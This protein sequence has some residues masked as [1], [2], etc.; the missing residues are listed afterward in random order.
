MPGLGQKPSPGRLRI[1]LGGREKEPSRNLEDKL[2]EKKSQAIYRLL[3]PMSPSLINDRVWLV[4]P[5]EGL[6]TRVV[7]GYLDYDQ[8]SQIEP[9]QLLHQFTQNGLADAQKGLAD[10]D[11]VNDLEP[12]AFKALPSLQQMKRELEVRMFSMFSPLSK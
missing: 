8:L 2:Y 5:R 4:K 6:S 7:F 10:A 1:E 9:S 3:F 11:F 12:P